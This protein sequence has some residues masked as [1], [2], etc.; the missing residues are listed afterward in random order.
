MISEELKE[1]LEYL[2]VEWRVSNCGMGN[3]IFY[4]KAYPKL[5]VIYVDR[6]FKDYTK[7]RFLE[8]G[9]YPE[10]APHLV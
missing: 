3:R 9:I 4:G 7:K 2:K 1:L 8:H 5:H 6:C 10:Y